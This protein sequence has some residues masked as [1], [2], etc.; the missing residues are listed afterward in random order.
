MLPA[1]VPC[2]AQDRPEVSAADL[3]R[4]SMLPQ[5]SFGMAVEAAED[6]PVARVTTTGGEFLIQ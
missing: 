1:A 6:G 3:L 5:A 4:P 2:R